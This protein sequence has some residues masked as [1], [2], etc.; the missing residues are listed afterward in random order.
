MSLSNKLER[1]SD[2][3]DFYSNVLNKKIEKMNDTTIKNKKA[4]LAKWN[5]CKI[6][7]NRELK[8]IDNKLNRFIKDSNN[9]I[10]QIKLNSVNK[11][12]RFGND[13]NDENEEDEINNSNVINTPNQIRRRLFMDD[14]EESDFDSEN[15]VEEETEQDIQGTPPTPIPVTPVTPIENSEVLTIES[16]FNTPVPVQSRSI[17]MANEFIKNV[18]EQNDINVKLYNCM[19]YGTFL[20][21]FNMYVGAAINE[22]EYRQDLENS[23]NMLDLFLSCLKNNDAYLAG[24]FINMAVNYPTI[25]NSFNTDLDIYVNKRNFKNLYSE[26][27]NIGYLVYYY[28]DISSP[29]MESFFKKNGLLS[30]LVLNIRNIKIDIL[31]IRDDYDLKDVV[32]NFDLTYCSV[33][34]DPEDMKIKG[35]IEDMKNK[36]GKLNDDYAEKYLFNKFIQNRLKKY[37]ERGYKTSIKTNIDVIIQD[38]KKN[39]V[40][41][42]SVVVHKLL[43]QIFSK[44]KTV[45][46]LPELIVIISILEY[47]KQNII[48]FAK[49]IANILYQDER[50]YYYILI[51]AGE[52]IL[53][54]IDPSFGRE[55]IE[56]P[57]INPNLHKFLS[58]LG[59]FMNELKDTAKEKKEEQFLEKPKNTSKIILLLKN[60]RVTKLLKAIK[61]SFEINNNLINELINTSN[62]NT[63]IS[64]NELLLNCSDSFLSDP[65]YVNT[66]MTILKKYYFIQ[67]QEDIFEDYWFAQQKFYKATLINF[68]EFKNKITEY[69]SSDIDFRE[70]MYYDLYEAEEKPYDEV[71]EDSDNL[72]FVLEDTKNGFTYTFDTLTTQDLSEFILECT[73]D[74]LSAPMLSQIKDENVWYSQL[75]SPYNIGVLVSQLYQAYSLYENSNKEIRKFVFS[76]HKQLQ[77]VSN[78]KA[79][80]WEN[81]GINIWGE[82][83]NLVSATHCGIG[84]KVYDKVMYHK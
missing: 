70:I 38:E 80:Q 84:M 43:L 45:V 23:K 48:K 66:I 7:L 15:E 29:Y 46:E 57:E 54:N 42:N 51:N 81:S 33:Y 14:N 77:H 31:I 59:V 17:N 9:C 34:L 63:K 6:N 40:I 30:R 39:K 4:K 65:K 52:S 62:E 56:N 20:S 11:T 76:S 71:Y 5:K 60:D 10:N 58:I 25:F 16:D 78:I 12:F 53:E 82:Y 68:Y 69:R 41:N 67:Y 19:L 36:S 64:F 37:K 61:S 3:I 1:L 32:K 72:L 75:S 74:V 18:E 26:I 35:N 22:S 50:Y 24:G 73:Q 21:Y 49:K 8:V 55:I 27:K 79:I 83:I 13:E 28:Y 44:Y 2:K 47:S